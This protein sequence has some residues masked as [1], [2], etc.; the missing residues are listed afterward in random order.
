M[1]TSETPTFAALA[2]VASGES[3]GVQAFMTPSS[4]EATQAAATADLIAS[5]D[6]LPATLACG[7]PARS[8]LEAHGFRVTGQ[9]D[10]LYLSV[11]PP[12]GW[13]LREGWT[14]TVLEALDADGHVRFNFQHKVAAYD[15]RADIRPTPR[16]RTLVEYLDANGDRAPDSRSPGCAAIR[17]AVSDET[18]PVP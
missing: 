6:R 15:P 16:Y 1:T 12:K 14:S 7:T 13:T 9:P 5:F 17:F 18:G 8:F 11:E 4:I 3:S 2:A 10:A